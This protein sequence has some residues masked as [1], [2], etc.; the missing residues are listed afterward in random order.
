MV[1]VS[2]PISSLTPMDTTWR[3]STLQKGLGLFNYPIQDKDVIVDH[4]TVGRDQE[5]DRHLLAAR[6]QTDAY[7]AVAAYAKFCERVAVRRQA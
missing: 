5:V 2:C 3:I 1:D 7:G 6:I 4:S